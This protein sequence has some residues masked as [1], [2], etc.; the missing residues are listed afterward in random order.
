[1]VSSPAILDEKCYEV[2]SALKR[3]ELSANTVLLIGKHGTGKTQ[4]LSSLASSCGYQMLNVGQILSKTL[5][6]YSK[7]ERPSQVEALLD[8]ACSSE[9]VVLLDNTEIL[10]HP[11]LK[12][13]VMRLL[14]TIGRKRK[15]P[16]VVSIAGV[17]QNGNLLY[18]VSPF[19]DSKKYDIHEFFSVCM[20]DER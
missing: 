5:L 6:S 20:G 11:D 7:E 1:M 12:Q 8:E 16:I 15:Y 18:S 9:T 3:K 14:K 10:F 19:T 4:I 17:I 2:D 13:N